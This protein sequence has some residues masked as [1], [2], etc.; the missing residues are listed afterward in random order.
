MWLAAGGLPNMGRPLIY[1]QDGVI[2]GET[3][4]GE[5]INYPG[6]ELD[7]EFGMNGSLPHVTGVHREI[8]ESHVYEDVMQLVDW[9]LD[10][11]PSVASAEHARHVIEIFDAAYHSAKTGQV[12]E[13]TTTF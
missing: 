8:E 5:P 9:I 4:N 7:K 1:G 13:L 12:Q 10:G 6:R 11:T 2:N 3:I